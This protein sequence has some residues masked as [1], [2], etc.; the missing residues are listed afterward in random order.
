MS[1]TNRILNPKEFRENIRDKLAEN[2][3]NDKTAI[4]MEI[5]IYNYA[6]RESTNKKIIKK[7]DNPCFVSIYIDKMRS[8]FMNIGSNSEF[9]EKIKSGEIVPQDAAFMTHQEL[10]EHRWSDLIERK[11]IVDAN[12][13]NTNMEASTTLFTCSKCKSKRCT[14]YSLQLRSCDEGETIFIT[15]MDCGKRWKRNS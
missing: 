6:I 11:K 14:F 15:C 13:F 2:I 1:G 9:L 10:N 12:R 3:H 7:W 5:A 8:I 4:N